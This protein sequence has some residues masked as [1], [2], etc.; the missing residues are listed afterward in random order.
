MDPRSIA[1][2]SDGKLLVTDR[3]NG[4]LLICDNNGQNITEIS[5]I[6]DPLGRESRFK[7][8]YGVI[9]DGTDK[10]VVTDVELNAIFVF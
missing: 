6:V 3:E 5:G 9:V 8:P 7:Q 1:V 2:S 4:K 10:I